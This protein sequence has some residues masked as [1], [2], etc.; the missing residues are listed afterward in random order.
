MHGYIIS[1][2]VCNSGFQMLFLLEG[3]PQ[4]LLTFSVQ[5][6]VKRYVREKLTF[7]MV[8]GGVI[9]KLS[10]K[11]IKHI[12]VFRDSFKFH[13]CHASQYHNSYVLKSLE[14]K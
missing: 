10:D 12:K 1:S 14:T 13:L 5:I 11:E 2:N 3:Q 7:L 8:W 9:F 6:D 4:Y